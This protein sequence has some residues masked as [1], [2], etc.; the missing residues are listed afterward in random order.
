MNRNL[1]R[2]YPDGTLSTIAQGGGCANPLY[3]PASEAQF[4]LSRVAPAPDGTTLVV[5]YG[6]HRVRRLI[7]VLPARAPEILVASEDGAEFYVFDAH[8]R[9]LRTVDTL[10]QSTLRTFTYD[11]DGRL[12]G[13]Q[14]RN[15][16]L[17]TIDRDTAGVPTAI[18]APHGHTTLLDVDANGYLSSVQNPASELVTLGYTTDGLL[19]TMTDARLGEHAFTYDTAGRLTRDDRASGSWKT[20]TRTATSTGF[21][22]TLSTPLGRQTRY[23]V[24]KPATGKQQTRVTTTPSGSASTTLVKT[25]GEEVHTLAN[26]TMVTVRRG[27]DPRFGMQAPLVSQRTVTTPGGLTS[28]T[29]HTRAVAF[30]P[31]G[32]SLDLASLTDTHTVNGRAFTSHYDANTREWLMTSPLG[33]TVRVRM[34]AQGR[35]IRREVTGLDPVTYGYDTLGRLTSTQQGSRIGTSTYNLLGQVASTTDAA[36]G[37]ALFS[38]GTTGH[39]VSSEFPGSRLV[40]F[41]SDAHGNLTSITPPGRPAHVFT[42]TLADAMGSYAPPSVTGGG[43]PTVYGHDADEATTSVNLPDGTSVTYGYDTGGRLTTTTAPGITRTLSYLTGSGQVD[44]MTNSG[45]SN[46]SFVHDGALLKGVTWDGVVA[47]R[48]S[49]TYNADFQVTA[50]AINT[51]GGTTDYRYDGDGLLSGAGALDLT[52]NS[53][54]GLLTG[55]TLGTLTTTHGYNT[56]GEGQSLSATAG[57]TAL[58]SHTITGR[59]GLGRITDKTETVQGVTKSFH[60]TYDVAGRLE[61]VSINGVLSATYGYDSN[62]NRTLVTEAGVTRNA[63]YDAQD[64]LL[65]S[66]GTS[67]V[68]G[69]NG[70][71]QESLRTGDSNPTEYTYDSLGALRAVTR[72]DGT[73]VDYV[74]DALGR[75]VGRKVNGTL[76]QGFLYDGGLRVAAELDGSGAL[77]SRFVYATRSHVPDF[78]VKGGVTYR[79]ISDHLGSPRLVVNTATGVV[80]QRMDYDAWGRI[81][82]DTA[83]GFQPFGFAGGLHDALTGLTRFG[84]RDYDAETG[85]WTNKDPIRFEGGDTNLYAYAANDP[86]NL[87][88]PSGLDWSDW[89]DWDLAAAGDFAAAFGSTLSFGLTNFLNDFTGASAFVNKC[90]GMY[91]AGEWAGLGLSLAFGGAHLGRNA[92]YNGFKRLFHDPRTWGSVRSAWSRAAGGLRNKG[93]SLHHWLIPQRVGQ[94]N[95]GFN[96]MPLTAKFNSWMNNSTALRNGVEWGFRGVVAG[97]YGAPATAALNDP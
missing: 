80:A 88:D 15:G 51:S 95:A 49:Y 68:F 47:G 45:G 93:Q 41:S 81:T 72:N 46:L 61:T 3:T 55:T 8:G 32:T 16:Q 60:Y 34:D 30:A 26:G 14:D 65:T 21:E 97:I 84:A 92:A 96:Y 38:Y 12:T 17:T 85:R 2:L 24:L 90:S 35:V 33:K 39:L 40:G 23:Q 27:P 54:N 22:V 75:R 11:T 37:T 52:R 94:V 42:Y 89:Q 71:L 20:L 62:G 82:T 74:V 56:L 77:V 79:I 6:S 9:H 83:P 53:T 64:R 13:L 76:T 78:M 73:Q 63:T 59:D 44:R 5:D 29:S 50:M 67:F 1:F 4:C 19:T 25:S 66:G 86:V 87:I 91:N 31:G 18:V 48:V 57:S 28:T 43:L 7:P 58:Y 70:D 10:T 69:P 36:G